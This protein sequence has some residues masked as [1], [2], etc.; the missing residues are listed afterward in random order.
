MLLIFLSS[1]PKKLGGV[2]WIAV[3]SGV[4]RIWGA[5]L[6]PDM[7]RWDLDVVTTSCLHGTASPGQSS[8]DAVWARALGAETTVLLVGQCSTSTGI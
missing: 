7:L 1:I 6:Y 3:Q 4:F 2:R 8:L 5:C